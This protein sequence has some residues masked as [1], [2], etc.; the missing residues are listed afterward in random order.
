MCRWGPP[1]PEVGGSAW[2]AGR[3]VPEDGKG[4]M[5]V[6]VSL[7]LVPHSLRQA[8]LCSLS[9]CSASFF[10]EK[11]G[12]IFCCWLF[13]YCFICILGYKFPESGNLSFFPPQSVPGG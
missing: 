13:L 3:D 6:C 8:P 7:E 12:I 2:A 9:P 10:L 1:G 11:L 4:H 5:T